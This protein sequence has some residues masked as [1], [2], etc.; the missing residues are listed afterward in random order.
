MSQA[1]DPKKRRWKYS[2]ESKNRERREQD[3]RAGANQIEHEK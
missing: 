2:R 1:R 3:G